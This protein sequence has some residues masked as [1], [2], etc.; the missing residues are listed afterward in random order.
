MHQLTPALVWTSPATSCLPQLDVLSQPQEWPL[1]SK[2]HDRPR[3]V[4]VPPLVQAHAVG[5]GQPEDLSDPSGID[6]ILRVDEGAHGNGLH[7]LT[8]RVKQGSI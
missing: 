8:V 2:I 1:R 4:G 3:H 6:E 5:L 7:L